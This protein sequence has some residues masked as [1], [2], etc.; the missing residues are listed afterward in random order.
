MGALRSKVAEK[1]LPEYDYR[2]DPLNPQN[3]LAVKRLRW[4][5]DPDFFDYVDSKGLRLGGSYHV[6]INNTYPIR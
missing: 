4:R 3:Q 1:D 2:L 6:P 5:F